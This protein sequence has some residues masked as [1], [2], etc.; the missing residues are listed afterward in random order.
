MDRLTD[1]ELLSTPDASV[2]AKE[3]RAIWSERKVMDEGWLIGWFANAIETGRSA[4]LRALESRSEVKEDHPAILRLMD[5]GHQ[6]WD[7]GLDQAAKIIEES[8]RALA[9]RA[10][11]GAPSADYARGL[12]FAELAEANLCRA[13]KWHKGGLDDWSVADCATA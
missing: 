13:M 4:G 7:D 11:L 5:L 6:L 3:F 8:C 9:S 2:W 12:T 1:S 10:E